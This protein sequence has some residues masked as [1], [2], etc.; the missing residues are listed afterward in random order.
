MSSVD[1]HREKAKTKTDGLCQIAARDINKSVSMAGA[2]RSSCAP[3]FH[4]SR[5]HI[6]TQNNFPKE[7]EEE[8]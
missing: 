2:G 1:I 5:A 6:T 3:P 8:E 4:A 7:E